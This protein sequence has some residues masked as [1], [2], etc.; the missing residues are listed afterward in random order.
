MTNKLFIAA[1]TLVIL[2]AFALG[3]TRFTSIKTSVAQV[4][5]SFTAGDTTFPA[6]TY[7]VQ[8][9]NEKQLIVLR[10]ENRKGLML[11]AITQDAQ[12]A[13]PQSKLVF[14]RLGDHFFLKE[15]WIKGSHQGQTLR[16]GTLEKEIAHRQQESEQMVMV[17]AESR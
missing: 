4:P 12:N 16:T 3:Q 5:F 15:A 6:G 11:M 7:T 13:A 17:Q 14:R 10:G 8:M 1:T 9:D 2:A